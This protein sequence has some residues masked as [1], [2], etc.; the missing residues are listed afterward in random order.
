MSNMA[1]KLI[2]KWN[3]TGLLQ[4][5]KEDRLASAALLFEQLTVE[6]IRYS[7]SPLVS[8]TLL[9]VG[10][11]LVGEGH[12]ISSKWLFEDYKKFVNEQVAASPHGLVL[13]SIDYESDLV[14]KYCSEYLS[15]RP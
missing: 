13:P 6:M 9:P 11:R 3:G 15:R 14:Q 2:A 10:R 12:T 1:D 5:L 7:V 8:N 4:G